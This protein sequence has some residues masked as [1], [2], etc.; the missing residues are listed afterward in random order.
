TAHD[1]M[2]RNEWKF[3]IQQF[4]IHD[5]QVRAANRTRG[6]FD[7]N[8]SFERPRNRAVLEQQPLARLPQDHRFHRTKI[9]SVVCANLK[10]MTAGIM[11]VDRRRHSFCAEFTARPG[12][13]AHRIPR[14]TVWNSSR[15]DG[16]ECVLKP[17]A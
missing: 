1:L 9:G 5:M 14:V 6:D 12:V 16:G 2:A 11:K 8:L 3:W 10:K 4:P 13:V 7:E 17:F 15:L